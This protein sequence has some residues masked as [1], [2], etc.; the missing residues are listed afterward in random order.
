METTYIMCSDQFNIVKIRTLLDILATIGY[1]GFFTF[2][3]QCWIS[4]KKKMPKGA[5]VPALHPSDS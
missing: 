5:R 1:I 4:L 3:M 2:S